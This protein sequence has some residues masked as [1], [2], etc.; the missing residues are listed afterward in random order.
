MQDTYASIVA[1]ARTMLMDTESPQEMISVKT[2]SLRLVLETL[3]EIGGGLPSP[4]PDRRPTPS[5]QAV[6]D[7]A[8]RSV[9]GHIAAVDLE[10]NP[11]ETERPRG[12]L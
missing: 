9:A 7:G 6:A 12:R 1:L 4:L 3:I 10:L 11:P 2:A 5:A 8:R